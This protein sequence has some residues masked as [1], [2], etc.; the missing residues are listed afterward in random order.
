MKELVDVGISKQGN[1]YR[2]NER[3]REGKTEYCEYKYK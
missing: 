3:F 1:R 2:W